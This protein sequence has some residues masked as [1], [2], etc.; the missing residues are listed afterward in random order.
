MINSVTHPH[1]S[2]QSAN[3]AGKNA[4][5]RPP[6]AGGSDLATNA[7]EAVTVSADAQTTTQLLGAARGAQ[8]VDHATV[9]R[10]THAVQSGSY[11]VSPG[12]LARAITG[13]YKETSS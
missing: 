2:A 3:E 5:T 12:S 4:A 11:N 13:A 8:G 10:L 9:Q 7:A 1:N 6:Q